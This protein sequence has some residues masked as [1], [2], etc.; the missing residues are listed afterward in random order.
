M[1]KIEL[2]INQIA[3]KAKEV[4]EI[5][6]LRT[7]IGKKAEFSGSVYKIRKMSGFAFIILEL[8]DGLMQCVWSEETSKFSIEEIKENMCVT[9]K[10][11]VKEE[12]RSK[13]GFEV[14]AEE[15]TILSAPAEEMPV[16]INGKSIHASLETILDYRPITLR[17]EK[18]RAV[19]KIQE[20]LVRGMR[21]FFYQNHFTEIRTP[22]IVSEGAEG[23]SNIFSLD[24]F[25]KQA[26]LAQSPQFYKQMMV[27]VY[28]KV[29]EIG[30]VYR[31][32][33]HDT[34]RHLNEYT[35]VDFEMGYIKDFSEIMETETALLKEAFA[36][37]K[38]HYQ[39][40]LELLAVEVPVIDSI[41]AIR[42]ADA[43][44]LVSRVYKRAIKDTDDFEPEEE[45]LLGEL[46]KKECGSDFVFVT[47]YPEKKRPF[48]AME[49]PENR[50]YTLSFDL[51]FRGIEVTTGGQ[52]I[53]GY[54][55]Q[56][57]KMKKRNMDPELFTSYLMMHKYGMPPHGGLGIGLERLT[58]KLLNKDNI[59]YASLFP[60]DINR[61]VP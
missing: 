19:F 14:T 54:E 2:K 23:G 7:Q 17:N 13:I 21:E 57:E 26:Y 43:K 20:G 16:V 59:R 36:F 48:Y 60:R 3:S 24:Y 38:E 46:I 56:L 15:L 51:F 39:K 35:G 18:E 47:H 1:K 33:K 27:G 55:E 40:E 34:N 11:F 29:F 12:P 6:N 9:I 22:K 5:T 53:H 32:E 41:P 49:D 58:M 10:G 61:L 42:F 25:G 28:T 52:R 50:A 44:E 31:A 30:A 45:R 37:L 8:P 4:S